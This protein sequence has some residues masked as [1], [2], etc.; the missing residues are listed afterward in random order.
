MLGTDRATILIHQVID[1]FCDGGS[2]G[3]EGIVGIGG[4]TGDVKVHITIAHMPERDD[5]GISFR[6][7]SMI[8]PMPFSIGNSGSYPNSARAREIS[9]APFR[10]ESILPSR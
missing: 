2:R 5:Q 7:S 3:D 1:G 4:L 9:K 10:A 8:K 6:A